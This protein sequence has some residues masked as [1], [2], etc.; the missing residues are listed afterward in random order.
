MQLAIIPV[1]PAY[2]I[3]RGV[4]AFT[5]SIVVQFTHPYKLSLSWATGKIYGRQYTYVYILPYIYFKHILPVNPSIFINRQC[6]Q[7]LFRYY[8]HI[9]YSGAFWHSLA[10]IPRKK[11][12]KICTYNLSLS[13]RKRV[14]SVTVQVVGRRMK[15]QKN[16]MLTSIETFQI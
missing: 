6:N 3:F 1:L 4:L 5:C 2:L 12:T 9:W 16:T 15:L 8:W 14:N 10:V 11:F 7:L 13:S